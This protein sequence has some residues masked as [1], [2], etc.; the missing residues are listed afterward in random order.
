MQAQTLAPAALDEARQ[1]LEKAVAEG[2]IAGGELLVLLDGKPALHA[3]A[4]VLDVEDRTPW[5][6]NTIVRI[7]SM[8]KPIVSVAAMQLHEQGRFGLDDPVARYIPAFEQVRVLVEEDGERRLVKPKRPVT[9]RDLFR[10]TS[11]YSYGGGSVAEYYRREGMQYHGDGAMFPPELTLAEAAEAM[12]RI[13]LLHQPGERFTYGFNTDLLG[14][15]VE[16][17]S[18]RTLDAHLREAV[19]APLAMNDTGFAVPP[20]KADRFASCHTRKDGRLAVLDKRTTSPYLKGFKF[21]SGGGGLVSTAEDYGRFCRMLLE[22]GQLEGR[23]L[24]RPET[25]REMFR[26]QLEQAAGSFR[27]GLGFAISEVQLGEGAAARKAK[28]Y[29][30]GGYASTEF[31]VI[32]EAR[33][34]LVFLR[35]MIPTDNRLA[36]RLFQTIY[37]GVRW[38]DGE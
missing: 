24:L 26:N 17:W 19:L 36:N 2:E 7:Y 5:R 28:V 27:F 34:A 25:L 3:V 11:G 8:T 38:A 22:G 33:L 29:S 15:L 21:L 32:P 4:G 37:R 18:G 30:W 10:H 20:E 16:I 14:R 6:S 35:Q 13:P 31:R 1:R 12:A 23:R 9:V